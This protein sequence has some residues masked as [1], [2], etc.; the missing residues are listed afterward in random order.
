MV[1]GSAGIV[2]TASIVVIIGVGTA[3][4]GI[5]AVVGAGIIVIA[6]QRSAGLTETR[7]GVT[8]LGAGTDITVAAESIVGA[9]APAL[10]SHGTAIGS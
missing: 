7:G 8:S 4:H 6:I 2:V 1:T 5:A 9:K 3:E 10:T